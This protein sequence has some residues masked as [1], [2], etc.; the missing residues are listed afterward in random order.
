MSEDTIPNLREG[1]ISDFANDA[2]APTAYKLT[3]VVIEPHSIRETGKPE[4]D[5]TNLVAFFVITENLG[6][7]QIEVRLSIGD[8]INFINR[9]KLSGDEK[10]SMAIEKSYP[11]K[12]YFSPSGLEV[13]IIRLDLRVIEIQNLHRA[14]DGVYTY[15]LNCVTDHVFEANKICLK[16]PFNGTVGT[17]IYNIY[18]GDLEMPDE[19]LDI[20]KEETNIIKG[21]YPRLKARNALNWLRKHAHDSQTPTFL[22]QT[23]DGVVKYKS[24]KKLLS[25]HEQLSEQEKE[26]F[27]Y[28]YKPINTEEADKNDE[29]NIPAN[30][31]RF[32][33]ERKIIRTLTSKDGSS[34]FIAVD[35]GTY[36]SNTS[37]IDISTKEYKTSTFEYKGNDTL[38]SGKSFSK[39][40]EYEKNSDSKS[41]YISKNS[42]SFNDASNTYQELDKAEINS[43]LGALKSYQITINLA[44]DFNLRVGQIITLNIVE[45][46]REALGE[47]KVDEYQSG[48]YLITGIVHEF[49]EKYIQTLTLVRDTSPLDVDENTED[50]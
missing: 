48:K 25:E 28:V 27:T 40:E 31:K 9:A 6:S 7:Q 36:A 20:Q 14:K 16:R 8:S 46:E 22:Y 2:L 12:S 4:I 5:I 38:N 21:I 41:Y 44:G 24:Y 1:H 33:N 50:N 18:S 19:K 17:L 45:G 49:K 43:I 15:S 26:Y 3:E 42:G 35:E 47:G 29:A 13:D 10:I 23:M 37:T 39:A 34:K 32:T 11:S 30:S